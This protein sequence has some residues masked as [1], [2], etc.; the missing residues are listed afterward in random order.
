MYAHRGHLQEAENDAR[1]TAGVDATPRAQVPSRNSVK[2]RC[3]HVVTA[4]SFRRA[5][6]WTLSG[7][8]RRA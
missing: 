3:E 2:T 6:G 1:L 8:K 5:E 7:H 4:A